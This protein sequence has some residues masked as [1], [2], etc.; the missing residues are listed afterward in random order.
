MSGRCPGLH[1]SDCGHGRGSGGGRGGLVALAILAVIGAGIAR[2]VVHAVPAVGHAVGEVLH[3]LLVA[4]EI[5][6]L[7]AA[8][9]TTATLTALT[10]RKVRRHQAGRQ[11][12]R[13]EAERAKIE[14]ILRR[15]LDKP[16]VWTATVIPPDLAAPVNH[17]QEEQP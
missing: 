7:T 11:L 15:E 12:E 8:A 2:P 3:V 5:T 4:V 10:V 1:C 9:V 17:R 6:A 13:R 16:P 14:E